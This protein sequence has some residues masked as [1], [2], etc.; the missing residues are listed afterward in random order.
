M[1]EP[2]K[3]QFDRDVIELLTKRFVA[4][5][6]NFDG[7]AFS[8]RLLGEFPDLELKQRIN[9]VADCLAE[10]LPPNYEAALPI[11]VSVAKS[12]VEGFAAWPLCSFVERHGVDH[13]NDS[14]VA[15]EILTRQWSCEFAIRP[16]LQ[17]HLDITRSFLVTWVDH[18]D[19][20][21]R[22]LT[23]EGTRPSLP[24]GPKVQALID[25]PS[26]GIDLLQ[27]LR[28]DESETVRRSVANHLNDVAKSN[29]E[30]VVEVVGAW[31]DD[32]SISSSMMRHAL[33]T[34]VK[35]GHPGAL[36]I[37]GFTTSP[38][39]DVRSFTC[40]PDEIG[41]GSVIE[42]TTDFSSV[43]SEPQQLLIDF[44]VHHVNASGATSPKVFKWTTVNLDPGEAT[45]LVK[46]R[47][48]QTA[49]TRS[50]HSGYHHVE[51]QIGGQVLAT[52][53]FNLTESS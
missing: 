8:A 40:S 52:T 26:I 37:L 13:P 21:V 24:W 34:L 7:D 41:L 18:E 36:T 15:M 43:G 32:P 6:S 22:R 12:G 1:A 44:V 39:V 19:E 16:F 20:A 28:H 42:L 10:G 31:A 23:S 35:Q 49:S 51:L 48:I 5:H 9:L 38:Q 14:L 46:R 25:D 11:V 50:Y 2:L 4:E 47:K 27:T 53:S 45:T 3:D 17:N 33:R 30:L 29:P